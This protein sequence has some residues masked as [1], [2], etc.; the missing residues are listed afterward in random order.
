MLSVLLHA[1]V[2]GAVMW[3]P[4]EALPEPPPVEAI[5]VEIVPAEDAPEPP[6]PEEQPEPEPTLEELRLN[7]EDSDETPTELEALATDSTPA[8]TDAAAEGDPEQ[9]AAASDDPSAQDGSDGG[10]Q[11]PGG[12]P[13]AEAPVPVEL[14]AGAPDSLFGESATGEDGDTEAA[15]TGGEEGE[16][17]ET[18]APEPEA[19]T[20]VSEET[21]T[22][23]SADAAAEETEPQESPTEET[24]TEDTPTEDTPAEAADETGTELPDIL[25]SDQ[26]AEDSI[27]APGG[28][29]SEQADTAE[30]VEPTDDL[31]DPIGITR[32]L[33]VPVP[34]PQRAARN[35]LPEQIDTTQLTLNQALRAALAEGVGVAG[36]GEADGQRSA[37]VAYTE[38]VR[39]AVA[40]R[41]WNE[42]RS[43][44]ASGLVVV[45]IVIL[46]NGTVQAA[47]IVDSSASGELDNA[48]LTATQIASY[49]P[50]PPTMEGDQLIVH[51]PL[52]AR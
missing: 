16:E 13:G 35:T 19:E 15:S 43:V 11:A 7:F 41:F 49:P 38:A 31:E 50:F 5:E 10:G 28:E 2:I 17:A 29:A 39:A 48:A 42:M 12:D 18:E 37:Q 27:S 44:S 45:E 47:R 4:A 30:D 24:V 9:A 46:R 8:P 3:E 32:D 14:N 22:P 51:I 26:P 33:V 52:R 21:G 1:A 20:A 36:S 25:T 34:N 40:P 6:A 23:S